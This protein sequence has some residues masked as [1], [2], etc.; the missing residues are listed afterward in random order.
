[1]TGAV[2]PLLDPQELL[3]WAP[4]LSDVGFLNVREVMKKF[5]EDITPSDWEKL[6][7]EVYRGNS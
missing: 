1:V 2:T 5:S 4:E 3:E 6:S 7:L